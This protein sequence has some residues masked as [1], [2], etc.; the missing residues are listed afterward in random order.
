MK[1]TNNHYWNVYIDKDLFFD[2]VKKWDLEID[3]EYPN[4]KIKKC[5]D[6]VRY[7]LMDEGDWVIEINKSNTLGCGKKYEVCSKIFFPTEI[8]EVGRKMGYC[9]LGTRMMERSVFAWDLDFEEY[10]NMSTMYSNDKNGEWR[11]MLED[12]GFIIVENC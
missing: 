12:E 4:E 6:W 3:E 7:N 5:K 10:G 9:W 2:L 1:K 8:V 11:K